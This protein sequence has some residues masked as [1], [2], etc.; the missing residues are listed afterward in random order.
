MAASIANPHKQFQFQI[1]IE[2]MDS[3]LAQ[4]VTLPSPEIDVAE[5]G[6]R[7]HIIKTAGIIKFDT[8]KVEKISWG[9]NIWSGDGYAAGD[10]ILSSG[11]IA[12]VD[13]I[14]KWVHQIQ[15]CLYGGGTLPSQYKQDIVVSK[16]G[17]DGHSEI[18]TW[19][20]LG[21][22]PSKINGVELSRVDSENTIESIEFQVDEFLP[23]A[24]RTDNTINNINPR[25][26]ARG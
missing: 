17:T 3:M 11:D 18:G 19:K 13:N 22:W 12:N 15:N 25:V 16:F 8:L 2:G 14:W 1:T 21:A 9:G 24:K 7:N 26:I 6:D 10:N 20:C 23:L 4:K 5:H